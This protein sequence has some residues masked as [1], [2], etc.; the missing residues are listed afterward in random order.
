MSD[1]HTLQL[2]SYVHILTQ[3]DDD[4]PECSRISSKKC[5]TSLCV[6]NFATELYHHSFQPC[7]YVDTSTQKDN[8]S[9][10]VYSRMS[11]NTTCITSFMCR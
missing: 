4:S 11:R 5:I 3:K 2:C 8:Y 6:V 10:D 1:H 7:S 9:P